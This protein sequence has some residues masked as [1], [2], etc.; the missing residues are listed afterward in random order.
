M[1]AESVE[2]FGLPNALPLPLRGPLEYPSIKPSFEHAFAEKLAA[3]TIPVVRF[4]DGTHVMDS[5]RIADAI[6]ARYPEPSIRMDSP[7]VAKVEELM[8]Q[9]V[10]SIFGLFV[11]R[12]PERLLNTVSADYFRPTREQRVGMPLDQYEKVA[13]GQIAIDKARPFIQ[14]LTALLGENAGGPFFMGDTVCYGDLTWAAFLIFSRRVGEDMFEEIMS[15]VGDRGVHE[16]LL[17]AI[18]P[19]AKRCS[20]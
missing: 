20:Y 19:W 16:R 1:V 7:Y 8:T 3:Y 17:E 6:E 9:I 12:V 13:G 4:P 18:A 14:Q 11:N 10:P 5:G 2:E 15:M